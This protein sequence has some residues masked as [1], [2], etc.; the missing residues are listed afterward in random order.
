MSELEEGGGAPCSRI[1][2]TEGVYKVV[3]QKSIPAQGGAQRTAVRLE[4]IGFTA[5]AL[6]ALDI[7]G[8]LTRVVPAG[9][10]RLQ[11]NALP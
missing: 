8:L 4:R 6:E 9:E 1:R 3:L 10:P 2:L 5:V 11:E 7:F